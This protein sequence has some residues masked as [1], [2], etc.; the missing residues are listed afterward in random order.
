[1]I[2]AAAG[3]R[4]D[5]SRALIIFAKKPLPGAVKTRLSP[6]L[7]PEN[8]AALYACM[9]QDTLEMAHTLAGITPF[10]FFQDDPGCR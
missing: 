6:P 8:A 2:T 7:T 3:Q 1:M 10:I 9:L 5:T 4:A